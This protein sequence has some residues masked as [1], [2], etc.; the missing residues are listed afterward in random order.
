MTAKFSPQTLAN[1]HRT[2]E[3]WLSRLDGVSESRIRPVY[4]CPACNEQHD[5]RSDAADCCADDIGPDYP[6]P[7]CGDLH[8]SE[9][10][11]RECCGAVANLHGHCP[12]CDTAH[13]TTHEAAD[14]C[15][16]KDTTPHQRFLIASR[17][18]ADP[19][20]TWQE[21]IEYAMSQP[22]PI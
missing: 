16:W 4:V 11:A 6:C 21:A 20:I 1:M 7:V 9:A 3:G 19:R 15:L 14:C 8:I 12:V 2:R 13:N 22:Q 5:C 17:L 10:D 18:E